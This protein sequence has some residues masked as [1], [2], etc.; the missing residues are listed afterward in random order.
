MGIIIKPLLETDARTILMLAPCMDLDRY[1]LHHIMDAPPEASMV[2]SPSMKFS[3]CYGI[4]VKLVMEGSVLQV[5]FGEQ[6][7][8]AAQRFG[9]VSRKNPIPMWRVSGGDY[10]GYGRNY[11]EAICK[12]AICKK[13]DIK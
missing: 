6:N 5:S 4:L 3:D 2:L 13:F 12:Y 7:F 8:D 11:Q 10:V 9:Q 1:V